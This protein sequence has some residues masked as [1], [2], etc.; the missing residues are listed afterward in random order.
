MLIKDND[1]NGGNRRGMMNMADFGMVSNSSGFDNEMEI[2]QSHNLAI[3]TVRD[4]KLY[5]SYRT[6]GRI[7][8]RLLYKNQ[9]ISADIDSASLDNLNAPI[10]MEVTR[11][12]SQYHVKG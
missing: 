5:V 12:G 8:D 9:P 1:G 2:L 7:R 10:Q 6:N 11:K 3:Q 4:I